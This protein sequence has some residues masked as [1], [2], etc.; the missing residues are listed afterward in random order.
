MGFF[1]GL[2]VAAIVVLPIFYGVFGFI[3]GMIW[4]AIYNLI[5][6]VVGG[7]ELEFERR[8]TLADAP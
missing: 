5:T 1:I 3:I 6:G 7:L 8:T 2:G 4:A